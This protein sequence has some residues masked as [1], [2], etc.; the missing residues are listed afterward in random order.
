M[1]TKEAFIADAQN[2]SY[3]VRIAGN[4]WKAF[5]MQAFCSRKYN[6]GFAREM[7]RSVREYL[8]DCHL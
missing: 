4:G 7:T 8:K 3:S 6:S 5:W 1:Y 2:V